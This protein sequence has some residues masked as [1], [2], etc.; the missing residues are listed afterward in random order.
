MFRPGRSE[1]A[2]LVLNPK[3]F[4]FPLS[5]GMS[6]DTVSFREQIGGGTE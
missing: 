4:L 6:H 3:S 2:G 5:I 1:T